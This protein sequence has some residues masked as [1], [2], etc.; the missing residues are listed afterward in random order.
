MSPSDWTKV[1]LALRH[2]IAGQIPDWTDGSQHDPG[3]TV[4][5]VLAYLLEAAVSYTT[6]DHER[7]ASAVA[8]ISDAASRLEVP[9]TADV[10]VDG[11]RWTSVARL[12]DVGPEDRV[13]SLDP[14]GRVVF[15]DGV[16]GQRPAAGSRIAY[17]S[18]AGVDGNVGVT[19]RTTWPLPFRRCTVELDVAGAISIRCARDRA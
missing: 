2:A 6:I 14:D 11:D 17:R 1:E 13:F 8:R 3:I 16:H 18:G 12:N 4:L 9:V 7:A 19:V 10:T 15:G 5:E